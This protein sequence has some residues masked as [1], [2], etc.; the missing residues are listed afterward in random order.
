MKE[1]KNVIA[2]SENDEAISKDVIAS[3]FDKLR[4]RN[5]SLPELPKG[6]VWTRVGEISL[7]E[8]ANPAPQGK[9]HFEN[10]TYPFVRVQDMGNLGN[11][12]Y[13]QNTRDHINTNA[14]KK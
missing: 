12:V 11:N 6:W 10:G 7:I 4:A 14:I 8:A 13:I 3:P 9:E 1:D 5:D 2:R